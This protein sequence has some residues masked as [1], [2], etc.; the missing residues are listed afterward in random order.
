[1]MPSPSR[2]TFPKSPTSI[3]KNH[4]V[5]VIPPVESSLAQKP[6]LGCALPTPTR[7]ASAPAV[8][9]IGVLALWRGREHGALSGSGVS[10]RVAVAVGVLVGVS[11]TVVVGVTVGVSVLLRQKRW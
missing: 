7:G 11:V 3:K 5:F 2:S 6:E 10:V 4:G 8:I 9:R 1:M